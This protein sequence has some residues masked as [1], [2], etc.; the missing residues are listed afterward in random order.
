MQISAKNTF[1]G[2]VS[3]IVTGAVHD[4][5][6]L[7]LDNGIKIVSTIT[8]TSTARL[9]LEVGKEAY[10]IIK[11]SLF[12]LMNNA[13]EFL[14]STRNQFDGKVIKLSRGFVNGEVLLETDSGME[15]T[16]IISLDGVNRLKLKQG[17]NVTALVK[18]SHVVLAVKK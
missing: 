7:T 9:G 6:E 13:D 16:V 12:I 1:C 14:L 5:V 10:A 4:E 8:R 2:K 17:Q 18:S 11:A 15:L 3:A